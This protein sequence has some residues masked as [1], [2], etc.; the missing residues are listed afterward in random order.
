[1]ILII[2]MSWKRDSLGFFEFVQPI[3]NVIEPI[4]KCTVK[5]Y[6]ELTKRDLQQCSKVILSGTTLKDNSFL[7]ESGKFKWL[8]TFDKYVL[9][10]CAGMEIMGKVFG[11]G[12]IQC[13]EIGMTPISTVAVN[14]LFSG[15]FSAYSLHGFC[16]EVSGDWRILANSANCAQAIKHK[17]KNLYGVLFHP[18][19][20]NPQILQRF[21]ELK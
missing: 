16:L 21:V 1:M 13:A 4:V 8:E 10:V 15:S 20:R 11:A 9:G 6:L 17:Q 2:D 3:L 18:E 5:H 14:P 12:L 7:A 19:V